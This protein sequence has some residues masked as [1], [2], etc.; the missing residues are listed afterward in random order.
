MITAASIM[1]ELARALRSMGYSDHH[2]FEVE[3]WVL[4]R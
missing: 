2:V 4:A 1:L 3:S